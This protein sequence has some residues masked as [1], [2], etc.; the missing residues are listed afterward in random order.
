MPAVAASPKVDYI[1]EE[2][3]SLQPRY[4]L[5]RDC[6]AGQEQIKKA[7]VKYL[8]KPNAEDTSEEN[9]KR[10]A[11]YLERAVFYGVTGRTL[12]GMVGEVFKKEPVAVLPSALEILRLDADGGGVSL[13]Q[14]AKKALSLNLQFGRLGVLVDYPRTQGPATVADLQAGRIRPNILIWQ[15]W[16]VINWRTIVSGGQRILSLVVIAEQWVV[17]DDGFAAECDRRF[18]VL[19]L[20]E[21]IYKVEI[22]EESE[23]AAKGFEITEE[24]VPTD[25]AGR[26]WNVIPFTFVGAENNDPTPDLPPLYDL[27]ALNVAHYRNSADYEEASFMVGQP[28]PYVSGLTKDWVEDVFKGKIYLGSRAVIALPVGG[29]AGLLQVNA[30]TM[31]AEAM[32]HKEAQMV[33]LGAKLVEQREVQ[34]TATEAKQANATE[35]SILA[36]CATN[37][38][39]AL[40]QAL[41]WANAFVST[42]TAETSYELSTDFEL[43]KLTAA[44]LGAVIAAWQ[45]NAIS[46]TEMRDY[47]KRTGVAFQDDEE[48]QTEIDNAGPDLGSPVNAEEL[49]AKAAAAKAKAQAKPPTAPA[50]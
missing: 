16:D 4:D 34:Q 42:A 8:P 17:D 10:Y 37:V 29:A 3:K 32:K 9:E 49:A 44:E 38:S 13:D 21:G 46:K 40:T 35:T 28:T 6:V 48:F 27:A 20:A 1:R 7:G 5:V 12:G 36:S 31:P 25:A 15:P 24:Y 30:N 43:S 33:A 2:I 45:A 26:P 14:I 47:A 11:N 19:R 39:A 18:R 22:W 41:K 23:D 50:A